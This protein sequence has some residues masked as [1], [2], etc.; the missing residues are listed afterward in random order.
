MLSRELMG[1]LAL[2]ILWLNT[3]LVL[4]VALKQLGNVL[5]LRGRFVRAAQRGELVRG[6]VARAAGARFAVRRIHM[7]GRALTTKG[8]DRILFTDGP[9]SFEVL[10]G[11]VIT[12]A[13]DRLEVSAAQSAASE[14]WIDPVR[15]AEG[16]ACS[17]G[18][19]FDRAFGLAS[20]FKGFAREVEL[21]LR[22]GDRVWVY[23]A[24]EG[25][26]LQPT[27]HEPLVVS[28][29]DPVAFCA[30]RARLLVLFVLG[31]GL[32]LVAVTGL[33]LVPPYFGLV[34]TIGGALGLAYFLLI[35]PLGTAVRDAVK[36]P[37]R[38]LVGALWVRPRAS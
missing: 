7:T 33:A 37:A 26:R 24:R 19:E 4:A 10:G 34:S 18:E 16:A 25:D 9:Q 3:G 29:V 38:R 22:E 5:A 2:G 12:D 6:K 17:S 11:E 14:V 8:P 32:A 27:D 15:A 28:M 21:E 31:A 23:G 35:Q 20:T 13:G 36:T 30:S 1:L